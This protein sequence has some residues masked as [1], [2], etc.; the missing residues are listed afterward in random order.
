MAASK[1]FAWGFTILGSGVILIG[2]YVGLF[3]V[4]PDAVQGDSARI[5]FVHVPAMW[6]SLFTYAFMVGA[7]LISIVWRHALADVAA[8]SAAPFGAAVTAFGLITGLIPALNAMRLN[9]V[10]ALGRS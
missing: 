8:K 2:V 10:T 3:V 7:S 9:I 5:M 1:W 6:L 4:P